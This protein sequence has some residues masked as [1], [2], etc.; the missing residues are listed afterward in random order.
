MPPPGWARSAH[1][2]RFGRARRSAGVC[3]ATFRSRQFDVGMF[4]YQNVV[5]A[6]SVQGVA[7][8]LEYPPPDY[9]TWA[10][11]AVQLESMWLVG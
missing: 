8:L 2:P 3:V 6:V 4:V 11:P 7:A 10:S 5:G 1:L 9:R